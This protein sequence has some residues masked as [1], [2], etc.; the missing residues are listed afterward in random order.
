[1]KKPVI[2]DNE[3]EA[4]GFAVISTGGGFEAWHLAKGKYHL[5]LTNGLDSAKGLT[6]NDHLCLGYY[7]TGHGDQVEGIEG[8]W[9][10][11]KGAIEAFIDGSW[12][13]TQKA[14]RTRR[15]PQTNGPGM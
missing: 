2:L 8:L 14:S 4:L 7:R 13:A 5:L 12:Q 15:T 11:V 9:S 3:I 10:S 1:M 6:E